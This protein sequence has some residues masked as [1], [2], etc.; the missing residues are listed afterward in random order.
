MLSARPRETDLL[1]K[2]HLVDL[3]ICIGR[4]EAT[5]IS[6]I[7]NI[8]PLSDRFWWEVLNPTSDVDATC[9]KYNNSPT[10]QLQ[11]QASWNYSQR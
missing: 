4:R 1:G 6:L 10:N 8:V 5:L 3:E 11:T 7:L 2:E 9:P